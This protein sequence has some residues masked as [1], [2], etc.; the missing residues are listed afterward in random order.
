MEILEKLEEAKTEAINLWIDWIEQSKDYPYC[1]GECGGDL[2][3]FFCAAFDCEP[4]YKDCIY[5]RA[6]TMVDG[7]SKDIKSQLGIKV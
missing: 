5:I 2:H 6:K 1:E 4:H 7:L 3:C